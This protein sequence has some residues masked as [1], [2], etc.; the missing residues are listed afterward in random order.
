MMTKRMALCF[1]VIAQ[2]LG[3]R[4]PCWGSPD[5]CVPLPPQVLIC[6]LSSLAPLA[7]LRLVPNTNPREDVAHAAEEGRTEK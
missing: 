1:A 6:T 4:F 7:L 5:V 3:R 2:K